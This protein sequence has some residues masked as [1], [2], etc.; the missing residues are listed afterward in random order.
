MVWGY[1][2]DPDW[3]GE[4]YDIGYMSDSGSGDTVAQGLTKEDA[5]FII[6]AVRAHVGHPVTEATKGSA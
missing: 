1:P 6:R 3:D 2:D 5:E 4:T